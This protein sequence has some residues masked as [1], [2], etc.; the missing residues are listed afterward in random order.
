MTDNNTTYLPTV[1][2]VAGIIGLSS[3]WYKIDSNGQDL[4]NKNLDRSYQNYRLNLEAGKNSS[5]DFIIRE[6]Q[7]WHN[8][9]MICPH[10]HGGTQDR[11]VCISDPRE[12]N[13]NQIIVMEYSLKHNIGYQEK[14]EHAQKM[15]E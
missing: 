12:G 7:P 6:K 3:V 9:V 4:L 15:Y 5:N 14:G 2:N 11:I 10:K 1:P 13:G 8:V